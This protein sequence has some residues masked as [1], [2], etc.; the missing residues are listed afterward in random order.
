MHICFRSS[1]PKTFP[2]ILTNMFKVEIF[3]L[4]SKRTH[5]FIQI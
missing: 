2:L 4:F 1:F 5:S 3:A